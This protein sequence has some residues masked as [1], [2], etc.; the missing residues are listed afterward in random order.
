VV[1][2]W[3]TKIISLETGFDH[4]VVRRYFGL[5]KPNTYYFTDVEGYKTSIL[6][7]KGAE[8]EYLYLVSGGKKVAKLSQFY[9]KNYLELKDNIV[10][11]KIK[12]LGYEPYKSGREI[13]EIFV[14]L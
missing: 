13:K 1:G 7:A 6:P 10:S 12:Y 8:Y 11:L 9:H 5:G 3:R 4:F 2:E 14:K